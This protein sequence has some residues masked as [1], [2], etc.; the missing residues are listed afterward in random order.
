MR[1]LYELRLCQPD[2]AWQ[3]GAAN[4]SAEPIGAEANFAHDLN[5]WFVE[6]VSGIFAVDQRSVYRCSSARAAAAVALDSDSGWSCGGVF[7]KMDRRRNHRMGVCD[8]GV[9]LRGSFCVRFALHDS[10]DGGGNHVGAAGSRIAAQYGQK[11]RN[12]LTVAIYGAIVGL[13]VT[14]WPQLNRLTRDP[15]MGYLFD[16]TL[17]QVAAAMPKGPAVVLFGFDP[18]WNVTIEPVYNWQLAWPDDAKVIRVCD[19]GRA[20]SQYETVRLLRAGGSLDGRSIV[21]IRRIVA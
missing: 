14:N 3:S 12:Y 10:S 16:P 7:T 9:D 6:R 17:S 4:L 13:S 2:T 19:P 1:W 5:D 8:L 15:T 11:A 21:T 18:S 20:T